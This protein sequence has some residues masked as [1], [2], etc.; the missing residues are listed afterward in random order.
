MR[1][2]CCVFFH[3]ELVAMRACVNARQSVRYLLCSGSS[4]NRSTAV[5]CT[6]ATRLQCLCLDERRQSFSTSQH[7]SSRFRALCYIVGVGHLQGAP[8]NVP[9]KLSAIF[10]ATARK[11]NA[12]FY[13]RITSSDLHKETKRHLVFFYCCVVPTFRL[14][15]T[16]LKD[17]MHA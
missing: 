1:T 2:S 15:K 13:T 8:K 4:V 3:A 5:V 7:A 10:S 17:Q 16:S 14:L 11:F 6:S 12:K 9:L